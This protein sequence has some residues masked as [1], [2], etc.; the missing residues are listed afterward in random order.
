MTVLAPTPPQICRS[1]ARHFIVQAVDL[2]NLPYLLPHQHSTPFCEAAYLYSCTA[3][4]HSSLDQALLKPAK[5]RFH[6]QSKEASILW[7]YHKKQGTC[8][9]KLSNGTLKLFYSNNDITV[10]HHR[11]FLVVFISVSYTH[12]T[13]PTN[14]EV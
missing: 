8:L 7:S 12:L 14:R 10:L 5:N 4:A 6:C 11:P 2:P 13:L 3:T 9:E 1:S